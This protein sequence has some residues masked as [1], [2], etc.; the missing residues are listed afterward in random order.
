MSGKLLHKIEI[1]YINV[2]PH[3]EITVVLLIVVGVNFREWRVL[4]FLNQIAVAHNEQYFLWK[5]SS[6][7]GY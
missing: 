7:V 1:Y 2:L 3:K 5:W 6:L 4:S